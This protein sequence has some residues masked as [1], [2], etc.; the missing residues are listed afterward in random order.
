SLHDGKQALVKARLVRRLL[1]LGLTGFDQYL[2]YLESDES[3][4]EL[5]AMIDVLTTNKTSFFREPTHFKLA[6]ERIIPTDWRRQS[7]IRLWSAGC[8]SGEEPYS[9]AITL[10]ECMPDLDRRDVRILA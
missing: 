7:T 3:G 8:S 9:L 2:D 4:V 10:R 5:R 1:Y 6:R